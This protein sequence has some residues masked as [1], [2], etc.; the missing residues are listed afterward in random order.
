M[1]QPIMQSITCFLRLSR[2]K[3]VSVLLSAA[4]C[5]SFGADSGL[6]GSGQPSHAAE[7][8]CLVKEYKS[9]DALL[10]QKVEQLVKIAEP[11]DMLGKPDEKVAAERKRL[12][13]HIHRADRLWRQLV[14]AECDALITASFGIG[15]GS[16]V[17]SLDCRITRTTDRITYLSKSAEYSW[18][19]GR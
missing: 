15:N 16:D 7:T 2:R 11:R 1:A 12:Q 18:L 10:R 17:A 13:G 6:C 19:W 9:T 14:E 5:A 4:C 3:C 8:D